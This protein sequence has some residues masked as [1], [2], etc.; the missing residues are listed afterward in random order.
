MIHRTNKETQA[1]KMTRKQKCDVS[2]V[3]H[4]K[5]RIVS[6]TA[7]NTNTDGLVVR[8]EIMT[9]AHGQDELWPVYD[10]LA[11]LRR[12]KTRK[13]RSEQPSRSLAIDM[14]AR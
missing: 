11:H 12:S 6:T 3:E 7:G 8:F 10:P 1:I 2:K 5:H 4:T 13:R 9:R 14:S